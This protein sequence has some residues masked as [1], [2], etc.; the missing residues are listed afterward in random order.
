MST[1]R[2]AKQPTSV[3]ID[4]LKSDA[5]TVTKLALRPGGVRVVDDTGREAFRLVIPSK[6]LE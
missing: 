1:S 2:R 4:A 3:R 5:A 6:P